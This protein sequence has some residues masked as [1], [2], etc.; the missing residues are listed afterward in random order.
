MASPSTLYPQFPAVEA[1]R[2][3]V[4]V[5]ADTL[6]GIAQQTLHLLGWR[7]RIHSPG[8]VEYQQPSVAP[9][10]GISPSGV[11]DTIRHW[12]PSSPYT[13]HLLLVF[14]YQAYGASGTKYVRA[15]LDDL[16]LAST[17]DGGCE[18]SEANGGL[19]TRRLRAE[20]FGL[21]AYDYPINVA[22]SGIRLNDSPAATPTRPRP[23]F[24]PAA[25]RGN[26]L[27]LQWDTNNARLH[28][29]AVIE[30]FEAEIT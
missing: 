25:S 2:F 18:W 4:P 26:L 3:R 16:T 10:D 13:T 22:H 28:D 11:A 19:Q 12:F 27:G 23:L 6:A 1:T 8:H 9:I 5:Q 7:G 14:G 24:V 30:L 29:F 17:I 20:R 15:R 21:D